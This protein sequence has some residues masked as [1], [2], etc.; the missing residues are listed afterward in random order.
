MSMARYVFIVYADKGKRDCEMAGIRG[1]IT[2]DSELVLKN[3]AAI[4]SFLG[5]RRTTSESVVLP[6]Y[7]GE[8]L[9]WAL[10]F[11]L[12]R[13]NWQIINVL[14]YRYSEPLYANVSTDYHKIEELLLDGQ[15][16]IDNGD[17]RLV[18]TADAKVCSKSLVRVEGSTNNKCEIKKFSDGIKTIIE[19]ENYY[20]HKKIAFN[21]RIQF[22]D[23]CY[24]LWGNINLAPVVKEQIK[25]ST[26]DLLGK[27]QIWTKY[28]LPLKR[29]ILLT[30]GADKD[31]TSICQ[32]LLT[33]AVGI[34]CII[35]NACGLDYDCAAQLYH[36]ARDLSP[37]IV[38]IEDIDRMGQNRIK[39][40]YHKGSALISLLTLL[41]NVEEHEGI[42]TVAT[43]S[44]N[45]ALGKAIFC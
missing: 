12:E 27:K 5:T 23:I 18:I 6:V 43:A 11:H 17:H 21:G 42:V 29:C 9:A 31:K 37:C 13:K 39:F 16:L 7:Y 8:L 19:K 3:E 20:R 24:E 44:Y 25:A 26:I 35:T 4:K 2:E 32:A 1:R 41:G 15:L 34:T 10:K 14:G 38:F 45:D 36:L 28:G 40:G 30:G 22:M 33:E